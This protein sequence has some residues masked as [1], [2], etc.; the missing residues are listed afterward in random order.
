ML[1]QGCLLPNYISGISA[2]QPCTTH[3]M[4]QGTEEGEPGLDGASEWPPEQPV[5]GRKRGPH[6][7]QPTGSKRLGAS[8]VLH[9]GDSA[10]PGQAQATF[11]TCKRVGAFQPYVRPC[12]AQTHRI[13]VQI[14][15]D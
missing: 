11:C 13:Q 14:V 8:V 15:G 3:P 5:G 2:S 1:L 4:V 12:A 9:A 6:N 10:S 7:T